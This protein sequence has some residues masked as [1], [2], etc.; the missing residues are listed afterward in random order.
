MSPKYPLLNCCN[1]YSKGTRGRESHRKQI[2]LVGKWEFP[3]CSI[4]WYGEVH[5]L[6]RPWWLPS[7]PPGWPG[8]PQRAPSLPPRLNGLHFCPPNMKL[9]SAHKLRSKRWLSKQQLYQPLWSLQNAL[10]KVSLKNCHS[11]LNEETD[12]RFLTICVSPKYAV[13]RFAYAAV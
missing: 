7:V 4:M 11:R 9:L 1:L 2:Y 3:K 8:Q 13:G 5:A 10:T 6:P 12:V